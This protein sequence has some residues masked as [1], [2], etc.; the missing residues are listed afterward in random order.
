MKEKREIPD[1]ISIPADETI[2]L[3]FSAD[4]KALINFVNSVF[5]KKYD[6]NSA[7]F[8]MGNSNFVNSETFDRVLGDLDFNIDTDSY[9][10][11]FQTHFDKK[12]SLRIFVYGAAKAAENAAAKSGESSEIVM[13]YSLVIYLEENANIGDE[14]TYTLKYPD[15]TAPIE[16]NAPVLKMWKF[17]VNALLEREWFLLLPFTLIAYRRKFERVKGVEKHKDEFTAEFR[18]I[19]KIIG[20]LADAGKIS[21]Y[22]E[23]ILY[24]ATKHIAAYFNEKFIKD[25]EFQ[26]EVTAMTLTKFRTVM[27][28][29]LD[30]EREE[31]REEGREKLR[32]EL[33]RNM[34]AMN[35]NWDDI[36]KVTGISYER[37]RELAAL[38]LSS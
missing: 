15:S 26:K 5:G 3:V 30:K 35:Y 6:V 36:I 8:S 32:E 1:I 27:D 16:V 19:I 12:M 4:R 17:N 34:L 28:D 14:V 37:L 2:K 29:Y 22:L 13:P 20:N 38:T 7:K 11:E 31:G 18:R 25:A 33:A 9:H 21:T 23:G 24:G 10:F